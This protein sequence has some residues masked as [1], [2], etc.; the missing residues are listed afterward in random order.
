MKK[1]NKTKI[2]FKDI[3]ES[4]HFW[5]WL[6]FIGGSVYVYIHNEKL[7]S[8]NDFMKSLDAGSNFFLWMM[9]AALWV[10]IYSMLVFSDE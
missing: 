10:L 3:I 2:G 4:Y 9:G 5:A 7:L 8:Q 1:T 6:I